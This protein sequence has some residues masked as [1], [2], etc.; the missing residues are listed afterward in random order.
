MNIRE[1]EKFVGIILDN[2]LNFKEEIK[3]ILTRMA[4]SIKFLK[5]IMNCVPIK[6]RIALLDALVLNHIQ[7]SS[8]ML[9]GVRK[10]LMITSEKQFDW[11][12]KLCF[13]IKKYYRSTDLKIKKYNHAC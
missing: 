10:N 13:K 11:G 12:I 1:S 7:Y 9:V 3:R 5:D 4:C 8:F 2:K 6:T